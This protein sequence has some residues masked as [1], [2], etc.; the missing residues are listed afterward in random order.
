MGTTPTPPQVGQALRTL[1]RLMALPTGELVGFVIVVEH[2]DRTTSLAHNAPSVE[3]ACEF[4]AAVFAQQPH[5][6]D[7]KD[8]HF[9]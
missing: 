6:H 3:Q 7:G 5:Q 8:L 1:E 2:D 4:A 9:I